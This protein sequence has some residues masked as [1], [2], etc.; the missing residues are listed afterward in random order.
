MSS[1]VDLQMILGDDHSS[2]VAGPQSASGEHDGAGPGLRVL[3]GVSERVPA[4]R[5]RTR[6]EFERGQLDTA[7]GENGDRQEEEEE[8]EQDE[9]MLTASEFLRSHV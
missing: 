8:E 6:E 2:T 5:R 1:D 9:P 7:A 4:T 3:S